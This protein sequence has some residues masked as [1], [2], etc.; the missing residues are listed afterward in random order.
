MN[1]K[2]AFPIMMGSCAGLM[3]MAAVRFGERIAAARQR[4]P[5]S[6]LAASRALHRQPTRE[7]PAARRHPLA[8]HR[9]RVLTA[10]TLDSSR[11]EDRALVR[12][13]AEDQRLPHPRP[14]EQAS[15]RTNRSV[16]SKDPLRDTVLFTR[17]YIRCARIFRP[18][19]MPT[20]PMPDLT[21]RESQIMEI[22]YR[23]RRAS[24]E[25]VRAELPDAPGPSSVRKLLD[26]MIDRRLL[27]REY[28]GPAVRS[29]PGASRAGEPVGP[30][31]NHQDVL[32]QLAGV[33]DG[34][35][36]E[37]SSDSALGRRVQRLSTL[38]KRGRKETIDEHSFARTLPWAALVALLVKATALVCVAA[39]PVPAAAPRLG[40][41]QARCVGAD[42]RGLLLLPPLR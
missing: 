42:G 21:R 6:L 41:H 19:T 31:A 36:A 1:P 23:R 32:R 8:R 24:V 39:G 26:I 37:Q 4:P 3:P 20:S 5:D 22:L 34:G 17:E 38:L 27:E 13:Q 30:Q 29:L 12:G 10:A 16:S 40:R 35:A 11:T 7:I 33:G 25:D 9:R 15:A 28:D 14:P 2:A 18:K